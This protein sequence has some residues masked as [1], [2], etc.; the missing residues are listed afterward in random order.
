MELPVELPD[1]LATPR[2]LDF[3]VAVLEPEEG[4]SEEDEQVGGGLEWWWGGSGALVDVLAVEA[5]EDI[6]RPR[7][8]GDCEAQVSKGWRRRV[9]ACVFGGSG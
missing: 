9:A 6:C 4:N 5:R 8:G 2:R 7:G 1:F 3:S